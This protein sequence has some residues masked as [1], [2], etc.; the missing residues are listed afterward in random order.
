MLG[1]RR[2]ARV[3]HRHLRRSLHWSALRGTLTL[4]DGKARHVSPAVGAA[5]SEAPLLA[6]LVDFGSPQ[7]STA[8]LARELFHRP[9]GVQGQLRPTRNLSLPAAHLSPELV[10]QFVEAMLDVARVRAL[11]FGGPAG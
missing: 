7:H 10:A 9:G 4:L 5:L 11:C 2:A 3:P 8:E 1:W 6:T